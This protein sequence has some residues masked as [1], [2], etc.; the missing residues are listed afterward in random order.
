MLGGWDRDKGKLMGWVLWVLERLFFWRFCIR[1]F[2][3]L[4]IADRMVCFG[5]RLGMVSKKLAEEF[6]MQTLSNQG[7]G[8]GSSFINLAINDTSY[9]TM[10][11]RT[12]FF[13]IGPCRPVEIRD[14]S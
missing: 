2:W 12:L 6:W 7:F 9:T 8:Q 1:C 14:G 10:I 13:E 5:R 11:T 3:Y 4:N